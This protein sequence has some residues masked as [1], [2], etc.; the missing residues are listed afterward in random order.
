MPPAP[1]SRR[2]PLRTDRRAFRSVFSSKPQHIVVRG[3]RRLDNLHKL[4]KFGRR[5][6]RSPRSVHP[7]SRHPPIY[8]LILARAA[9]S[10][11]LTAKGRHR[12]GT[13]LKLLF[14]LF[15]LLLLLEALRAVASDLFHRIDDSLC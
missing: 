14:W 7:A 10:P 1:A 5:L 9:I 8:K 4:R 2:L 3:S 6:D 15:L 12:H 13:C 11:H